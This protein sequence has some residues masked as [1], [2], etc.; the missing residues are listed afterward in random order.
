[1]GYRDLAGRIRAA[2]DELGKESLSKYYNVAWNDTLG[3]SEI[4]VENNGRFKVI[5]VGDTRNL[6]ESRGVMYLFYANDENV[7]FPEEKEIERR[8]SLIAD[9]QALEDSDSR[10]FDWE[11]YGFLEQQREYFSEIVI[12]ESKIADADI[13][14][15]GN[16][17][18]L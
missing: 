14:K 12:R 4:I 9:K 17:H 3:T 13:T 8:L 18:D 1:M 11:E 5:I 15:E 7:E 10:Y 2:C 6:P 16:G